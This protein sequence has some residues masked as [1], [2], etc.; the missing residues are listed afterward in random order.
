MKKKNKTKK[1][2]FD[3]GME[4]TGKVDLLPFNRKI[5]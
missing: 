4:R 2:L 5:A 1:L 3:T